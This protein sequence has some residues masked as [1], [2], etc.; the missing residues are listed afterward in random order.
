MAWHQLVTPNTDIAEKA[1][2]C[3]SYS[4]RAFGAPA[5]EPTAWDAWTK[6][7]YRHEDRV[8]PE[9]VAH[10]VWF[11]WKNKL[12]GDTVAQ[13]YGHV[14]VRKADGKIWSSPLSGV[15]RAWFNSVDDLV[16]AFGGGMRYVGWSEDISKVRVIEESGMSEWGSNSVEAQKEIHRLFVHYI[17]YQ[18]TQAD[19]DNFEK[20]GRLSF[21]AAMA[22]YLVDRV[23]EKDAKIGELMQQVK[24]ASSGE[25]PAID[26]DVRVNGEKYVREAK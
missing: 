7:K 9:G 10:P 17:G 26:P 1:G 21:Y 16:R 5:V 15:G 11:Y 12:P 3:L 25:T 14:A 6:A 24:A 23:R 13:E 22:D 4:R 18:P 8:F 20:W 2:M 19:L